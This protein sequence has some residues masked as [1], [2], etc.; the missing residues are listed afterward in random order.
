MIDDGGYASIDEGN[1]GLSMGG[2]DRDER[3]DR[4]QLIDWNERNEF[5][6]CNE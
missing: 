3:I 5:T 2:N 1:L 4:N 6:E